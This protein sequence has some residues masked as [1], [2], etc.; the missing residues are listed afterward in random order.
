MADLR[1]SMA[2][3]LP[4]WQLGELF[5]VSGVRESGRPMAKVSICGRVSVLDR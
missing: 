5:G 2:T 4:M 3:V 1:K